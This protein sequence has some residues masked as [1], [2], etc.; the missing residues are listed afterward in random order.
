[1]RFYDVNSGEIIFSGHE[2]R[3]ITRA[4][5]REKYGMVLQES[6]LFEGTIF[7]NIAYV[8]PDATKEEVEA[9][10]KLAGVH[11]FVEKMPKG[12]QTMIENV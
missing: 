5:L 4:S 6:W 3:T 10:A 7:E 8:K 12:Y 1:M 9:A 11:S 2:I